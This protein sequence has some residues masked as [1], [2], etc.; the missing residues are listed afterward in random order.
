MLGVSL[1]SDNFAK[2]AH[3]KFRPVDTEVDGVFVTGC[4]QGPKDIPDSVA[5]AKAAAGAI[6]ALLA[7]GK[8]KIRPSVAEIDEEMCIG[9]NSLIEMAEKIGA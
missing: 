9:S 2:E 4:A 3:P 8:A 1:T 7:R 6:L 5:Q